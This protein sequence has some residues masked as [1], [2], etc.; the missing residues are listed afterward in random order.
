M[1]SKVEPSRA[2]AGPT[3]VKKSLHAKYSRVAAGDTRAMSLDEK[4][5]HEFAP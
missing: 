3:V 1:Q 2:N 5:W 4:I